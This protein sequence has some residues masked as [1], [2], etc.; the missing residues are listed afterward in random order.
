ML[1]F[2]KE[3]NHSRFSFKYYDDFVSIWVFNKLF[4]LLVFVPFEFDLYKYKGSFFYVLVFHK[5]EI[6]FLSF[7]SSVE[8]I[9]LC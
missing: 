6:N 8:A 4:N 7:R 3:L 1:G 2:Q 9:P 5:K